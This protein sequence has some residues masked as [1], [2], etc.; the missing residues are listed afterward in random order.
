MFEP[1][2]SAFSPSD[3]L[4]AP[5][6]LVCIAILFLVTVIVSEL[7]SDRY[8][9]RRRAVWGDISVVINHPGYVP[10]R[11]YGSRAS[12]DSY[13]IICSEALFPDSVSEIL[14]VLILQDQ[15]ERIHLGGCAREING[16]ICGALLPL[17]LY[18]GEQ[19][20]C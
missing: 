2:N 1:I 20:Q 6:T 5:S 18:A 15:I 14:S 8:V 3:A 10:V 17:L 13:L 12:G 19:K 9:V 7:R 4:T 11:S 16:E